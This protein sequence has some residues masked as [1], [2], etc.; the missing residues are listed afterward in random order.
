MAETSTMTIERG[1]GE[2]V[3]ITIQNLIKEHTGFTTAVNAWH[4]K[5]DNSWNINMYRTDCKKGAKQSLFEVGKGWDFVEAVEKLREHYLFWASAELDLDEVAKNTFEI[6]QILDN[7]SGNSRNDVGA[8]END[9]P[10]PNELLSEIADLK[11]KF[12]DILTQ[13]KTIR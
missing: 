7:R 6:Q 3:I 8:V 12:E 9:V 13:L 1:L 11:Q 4:S 5:R 2:N 10:T